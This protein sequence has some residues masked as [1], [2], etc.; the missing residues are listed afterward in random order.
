MSSVMVCWFSLVG[1]LLARFPVIT[2]YDT[3]LNRLIWY[4]NTTLSTL[5]TKL[6]PGISCYP[7]SCLGAQNEMEIKRDADAEIEL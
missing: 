3:N 1:L 4:F 5:A 2:P 6:N 7:S